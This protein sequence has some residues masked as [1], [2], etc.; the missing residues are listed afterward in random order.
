MPIMV[1]SSNTVIL[2]AEIKFLPEGQT[3]LNRDAEK[4]LLVA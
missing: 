1:T 2:A 3:A 4:C